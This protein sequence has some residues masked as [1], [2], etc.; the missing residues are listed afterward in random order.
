MRTHRSVAG[1]ELGLVLSLGANSA[2]RPLILVMKHRSK[3]YNNKESQLTILNLYT[4]KGSNLWQHRLL[5]KAKSPRLAKRVKTK[6]FNFGG[7]DDGQEQSLRWSP[8]V[9]PC[10]R[11]EILDLNKSL[12]L[13]ADKGIEDTFNPLARWTFYQSN[14][15]AQDP[16]K[17][18]QNTCS[19]IRQAISTYQHMDHNRVSPK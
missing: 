15:A 17:N 11:E 3:W 7:G 6:R 8:E 16:L 14:G 5:N 19:D 12:H 1:F 2:T 4:S 10:T 9:K 18:L 13:N